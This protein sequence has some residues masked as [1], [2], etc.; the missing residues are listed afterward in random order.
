M[1][2]IFAVGAS[3]TATIFMLTVATADDAEPSDA[4]TV[5]VFAPFS[6]GAG[7]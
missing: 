5:K 3:F 2:C 4:V 6:L 7:T 1:V